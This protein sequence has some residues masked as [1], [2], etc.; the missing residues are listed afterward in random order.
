MYKFSEELAVSEIGLIKEYFEKI[1]STLTSMDILAMDKAT[2]M[3]FN[4]YNDGYQIITMGNGGSA[5]TA[6]HFAGDLVKGV[7]YGLEKRV[8]A[9]CLS[10]NT[11]AMM[12]IA[13]DINYESIFSEQ[14]KNF[15]TPNDVVVAF[16][17]S[18]NSKNIINGIGYAK[19]L[20]AKTLGICGYQGGKLK[21]LSDLAIHAHID[22]MEVSEDI[23]M[24]VTHG[25]K[26]ALMQRIRREL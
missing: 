4:A 12:A 23:H 5:A 17:G 11:P 1:T 24:V 14:L 26:N 15:L 20:G 18:G 3:L 10:D 16:S 7:S 21:E 19:K 6:S 2:E 25:L 13:N 8:R 9:I 22:D